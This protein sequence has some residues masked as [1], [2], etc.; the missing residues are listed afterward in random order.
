[1]IEVITVQTVDL[2]EEFVMILDFLLS[3]GGNHPPTPSLRFQSFLPP[4]I[5]SA[6]VLVIV[7]DK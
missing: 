6:E 2:G 7:L 4:G 5:F 3:L 1:M